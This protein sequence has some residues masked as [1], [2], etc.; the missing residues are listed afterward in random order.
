M[1]LFDAL[2]ISASGLSAER[3]RMDVVAENLANAQSTRGAGGGPYRRKE[4]VLQEAGGGAF[5][6]ALDAARAGGSASR[7]VRVAAIVE[8]GAPDRLV[9]DPGHPDAD[10][11][12]Y[13]RMPNVNT[14]TEMV[15]LIAASRG[16]EANVTAMQ[17]AK[18]M[19]TKTLELL[20]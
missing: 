6:M 13:V 9:Y 16:Y 11:R 5:A 12:G 7:G 19:F 14:V 3:L 8:D 18:Q 1:G 17:A 20:R 10:A 15:D 2:E 4:V